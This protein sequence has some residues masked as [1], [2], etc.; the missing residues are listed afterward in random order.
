MASDATYAWMRDP[1]GNKDDIKTCW[2]DTE[3]YSWDWTVAGSASATCYETTNTII[4]PIFN[5]WS[6]STGSDASG[7]DWWLDRYWS[8]RGPKVGSASTHAAKSCMDILQKGGSTGDGTYWIDTDGQ[9]GDAPFQTYC[10]M[11]TDGGGWT[12]VAVCRPSDGNNCWSKDAVGTVINPD[13]ATTVKLSDPNIRSLIDENGITRA[14][15]SQDTRYC[16]SGGSATVY[17]KIVDPDNGWQSHGCGSSGVR[18]FYY[19]SSYG[20]SWGNII[21][22]TSTGCSC[23]ANGWS[24][25]RLDSCSITWVAGCEGAPSMSHMCDASVCGQERANVIVW[26]RSTPADYIELDFAEGDDG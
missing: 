22:A 14:Y 10:D 7:N 2:D 23:A 16:G 26:A 5:K 24:N 17:N 25:T 8:F 9:D 19:K 18:Q 13:S 1:D 11:T 3:L 20:A 12:L 15:W 6:C 4:T 21:V